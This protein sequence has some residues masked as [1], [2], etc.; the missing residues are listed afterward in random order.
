MPL[1]PFRC[2]K[3][4]LEIVQLSVMVYVRFP[5]S[6]RNVEDLLRKTTVTLYTSP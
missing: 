4:S 6:L 2:F 3:M 5:F 1:N